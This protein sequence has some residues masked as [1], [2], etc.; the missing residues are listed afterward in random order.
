MPQNAIHWFEIPAV[1][2]DRAVKFYNQVLGYAMAPF[3]MHNCTMAMF[4]CES[5]VGG[6]ICKQ[7]DFQPSKQGSLVYLDCGPDLSVAL[8]KIEAAGGKVVMPKTAIGEHGF[9]A[10]FHDTEGNRVGLHSD[11]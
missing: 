11:A 7:G 5:S 9:I 3:T 4:P 1:D 2:I 6:A 8:D 10:L